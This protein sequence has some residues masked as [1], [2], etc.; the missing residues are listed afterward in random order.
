MLVTTIANI[1]YIQ[2]KQLLDIFDEEG[3]VDED[4]LLHVRNVNTCNKVSTIT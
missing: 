4:A 3:P 1:A 2:L